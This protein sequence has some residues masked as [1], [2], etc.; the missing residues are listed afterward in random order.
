MV[1]VEDLENA[2]PELKESEDEKIRQWL[3]D[4]IQQIP[5]HSIEWEVINKEDVLAWLEK[6][7]EKKSEWTPMDEQRVEN[8]LAIIEGHGYPGEVTFLNSLRDRVQSKQV[9]QKPVPDWMPKFLDEL[10]TNKNY[11]DW[12]IEGSII[13]IIDWMNPNYFNKNDEQ[14]PYGQR[15]ECSNCQMNYAGECK[16]SCAM[17]R[18]EQKL[19][20]NDNAKEMFIKAL[21]RVEEQ[22]AKG[23]KLTDCDKNSW[24]ED[25]KNYTSCTIE[26]KSTW[27]EED[28]KLYNDLSDTYFYNDEDYPEETYKRMLKRALD[29]MNKRAKSLRPQSQWKPSL[30]QLNALGI[31]AKGNP[32]DDIE[33]IKSLYNDLH[34]LIN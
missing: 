22:N 28:E 23:Y 27:S 6:Q 1:P 16:G 7:G 5:N 33:E 17:K 14:K 3:I 10:R 11:S 21:E 31:V 15:E 9:K 8:L 30:S 26:Q 19:N 25:F 18:G 13:S 29:W 32:P 12:D 4:T 20:V 34:K 24:W 2:F